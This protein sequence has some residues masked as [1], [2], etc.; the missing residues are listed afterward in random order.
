MKLYVLSACGG[1]GCASCSA[2]NTCATCNSGLY[3]DPSNA[4]NCVGKYPF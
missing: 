1:T 4:A 3:I 2:D